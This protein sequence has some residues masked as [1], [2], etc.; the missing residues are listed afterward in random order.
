M[1]HGKKTPSHQNTSTS[2]IKMPAPPLS[3]LQNDPFCL[4]LYNHF[5]G[6]IRNASPHM[7]ELQIFE[8]IQS[9]AVH[10]NISNAFAAATLV[11]MGLRAPRKAFPASFLDYVDKIRTNTELRQNA[12]PSLMALNEHWHDL[13]ENFVFYTSASS[14]A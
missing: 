11:D 9:T 5:T 8:A 4:D 7:V 1:K 14:A 10:M 12:R 6:H 13:R 2:R 3:A